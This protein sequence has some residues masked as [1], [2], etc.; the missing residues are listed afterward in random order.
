MSRRTSGARLEPLYAGVMC[1][2][3]LGVPLRYERDVLA[4]ALACQTPGGGFAPAPSAL[5]DLQWTHLAI[6]TLLGA[7]PALRVGSVRQ[8]DKALTF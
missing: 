6:E 8:K 5:P 3:L 1:C 2:G 4:L 7:E